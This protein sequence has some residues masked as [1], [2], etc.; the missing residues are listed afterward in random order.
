M[1]VFVSSTTKDLGQARKK[2][3]ER[4]LQLDIQPVSMDWYTANGKPPKQVD[5]AKV[6]EC[7]A[8]VI[9]VGHLYGS[10]PPGEKKCFT[11]LEYEAALASGKLIHAFLASDKFTGERALR[12]D[13]VTY[14]KH[15]AFRERLEQDH[16][17][18][19]FDNEDQLCTE[20][21]VALASVAKSMRKLLVPLPPIVYLAHQYSLQ[22]NFTGRRTERAM[23]TEWVRAKDGQPMLSLVG[24]GGLGKSALT[25]Y[26][27]HAD[28]LQENLGFSGVIWW[29]FY[30]REANFEAFLRHAVFYTSARTIQPEEVP[31]DYDRMQSLFCILHDSPFLLILDGV[32]RLLRAYH[33]LG[34]AYKGD[35][36][37]AEAGDKHLLCADASAGTFLQWLASPGT[38]TKTLLTTRLQPKDLQGLAGCRT[39]DLERLDPDDAV[40]FFRRQG[41]KGP[42]TA[43]VH[44]C[45]PYD[46]LPLCL[47]LLS[48]AIRE[49]PEKPNDIDAAEGW[50]PPADLVA[51]EHHIL[52]VAYDTMAKDRQNLLSRIAAMRGPVDYET[53]KILSTYEEENELKEALRELVARGLLFRQQDKAHYDLHPIV[54]QYAYDRLGDKKAAHTALKD[55]FAAV[56]QPD[57]IESLDDLLPTIELFH[58][59]IRTG[60]YE[61]GFG[62]YQDRLFNPLYYQLG[63]YDVD[64]SLKTAFFPD[65]EDQPPR[66]KDESG[67][68]WILDA[69]AIAYAR[70][71]RSRKAVGLLERSKASY[72]K[73]GDKAAVARILGNLSNSQML[74]GELKTAEAN[75]NRCVQVSAEIKDWWE[76]VGHRELGLLLTYM[77][78]HVESHNEL[79]RALGMFAEQEHEQGQGQVWSDFAVRSILMDKSQS[80]LKAL[81]KARK[82]WEMDAKHIAPVELDLVRILWLSGA[83]KRRLND[84]PGAEMELNEALSRCRRIRLID[85]EDDTL[86]EMARLQYQKAN[87][88][89][90]ELVS[91]AKSLTREALEIADRCEYRLK[92]A[93]IHNFLAE[94][95]LAEN[96]KSAALKHAEIAMERAFCDGPPYCY[97]KA[98]DQTEQMLVNLRDR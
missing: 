41:I 77:G 67:Q 22:E 9:V 43:I 95:A 63:A 94:M 56:P 73:G 46:F 39:E 62:I 68:A 45:E 74:L 37:S 78:R 61:E 71:G 24:I 98:L 86:L 47:R 2:V 89:D 82:F 31:S 65:G 97:K 29:S 72:E 27:L 84:L 57:K 75:L 53:A 85:F 66:L 8:L 25:W 69:L 92:Q 76:S 36:F 44:A 10:S 34:A 7:A 80:A 81:K 19:E 4:L 42:R 48:G 51:R 87:S 96:D 21:V 35:D 50:H 52:Q 55:Y 13:D 12:E 54:R 14:E 70:T 5:E 90:K 11:E 64:I 40:E 32:E 79:E 3:C 6:K 33:A 38:K 20:V 91:Q 93:N 88:K 23:L 1:K 18:R 58:H 83:A 49:D 28:L 26:W 16:A 30:E 15:Q 60:A 17:P 59:T